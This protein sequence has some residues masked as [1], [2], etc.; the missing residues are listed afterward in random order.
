MLGGAWKIDY[1]SAGAFLM[2]EGT[3]IVSVA[4]L[5]LIIEVRFTRTASSWPLAQSLT[6]LVGA[7]VQ[8]CNPVKCVLDMW[9]MV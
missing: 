6:R 2:F 7:F 8:T 9:A 3:C 4:T 1:P 5:C